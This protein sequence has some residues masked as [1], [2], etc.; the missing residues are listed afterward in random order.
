MSEL[1]LSPGRRE[2]VWVRVC[3]GPNPNKWSAGSLSIPRPRVG[4]P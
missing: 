3:E 2:C 4:G 1:Q